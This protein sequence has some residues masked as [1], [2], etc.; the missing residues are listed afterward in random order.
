MTRAQGETVLVILADEAVQWDRG[1]SHKFTGDLLPKLAATRR[2]RENARLT[3]RAL[4]LRDGILVLISSCDQRACE[5]HAIDHELAECS[6]ELR[7]EHE[8]I[9]PPPPYMVP[10]SDL[11]IMASSKLLAMLV[12]NDSHLSPSTTKNESDHVL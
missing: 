1:A 5:C 12:E 2:V 3:A 10:P 11:D 8:A 7:V 4:E 6:P 9:Q